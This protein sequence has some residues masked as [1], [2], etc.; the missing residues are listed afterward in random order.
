M[1]RR[2]FVFTSVAFT[3]ILMSN[4]AALP[5][6]NK[7]IDPFV[8]K[9]GKARHD[10]ATP[11]RGIN[12]NNLKVSTSD[13][14]GQISCWVYE[15]MEK[16]GPPLHIHFDQDEFFFVISGEYYFVVGEEKHTLQAGDS[17]FLPRNVAHTWL[18]LSDTG[19]LIY[20]VNP[21]GKMEAFFEKMGSLQGP[22]TE[23]LVQEIHM[24]HGMKV[25][26]PP[27]SK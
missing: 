25:L 5:T 22:P 3:P 15:G 14:G 13:S 1:K 11:Y 7:N 21:A 10:K 2:D 27:I 26:G 19:K 6:E 4:T 24:A 23:E 20:W 16:I 9:S 17:I 8:V 18:Q 12:P